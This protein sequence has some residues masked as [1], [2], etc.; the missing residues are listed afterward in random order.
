[1][2]DILVFDNE[3]AITS[4]L[5]QTMRRMNPQFEK[6]AF[7]K[8][9]IVA[10]PLQYSIEGEKLTK[11]FVYAHIFQPSPFYLDQYV[12]LTGIQA[13]IKSNYLFITK[14]ETGSENTQIERSC[15]ILEDNEVFNE[16]D[17]SQSYHLLLIDKPVEGRYNQVNAS[18]TGIT[19]LHR[20]SIDEI[21]SYL[22]ND[23]QSSDAMQS[24]KR[25]VY[26]LTKGHKAPESVDRITDLK[27]RISLIIDAHYKLIAETNSHWSDCRSSQQRELILRCC[28]E[29]YVLEEL[30]STIIPLFRQ[31]DE[32]E[33]RLLNGYLAFVRGG[34]PLTAEELSIK[35]ILFTPQILRTAV[36]ALNRL[37]TA[38][39]VLSQLKV[40]W[41]AMRSIHNETEAYLTKKCVKME[42]ASDDLVPL[43]IMTLIQSS[44]TDLVST[45][46]YISEFDFTQLKE[47]ELGFC[48]SSFQVATV[49]LLAKAREHQLPLQQQPITPHAVLLSSSS[50]REQLLPPSQS[51]PQSGSFH[52]TRRSR[53][54][55]NPDRL[56]YRSN[57]GCP[58]NS[59]CTQNTPS[60][61]IGVSSTSVFS[62]LLHSYFHTESPVPPQ[63]DTPHGEAKYWWNVRG[64]GRWSKDWQ[65]GKFSLPWN[66]PLKKEEAKEE[67]VAP[68]QNSPRIAAP[69][70][71]KEEKEEVPAKKKKYFC[72][73][74]L[75]GDEEET[76]LLTIPSTPIIPPV[77]LRPEVSRAASVPSTPLKPGLVRDPPAAFSSRTLPTSTSQFRFSRESADLTDAREMR[78][79]FASADEGIGSFIQ[80]LKNSCEP[81]VSSRDW[82]L[83]HNDSIRSE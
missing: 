36:I 11:Q 15:R 28:I 10:I 45:V 18:H 31:K 1:M 61:P 55:F 83:S 67:T 62:D 44:L 75:E 32:K 12:S 35:P 56:V 71:V 52:A 53:L 50:A 37:S 66:Y 47:R 6:D 24:L 40:I 51:L 23:P 2:T 48:F 69:L 58:P 46:D 82:S 77:T 26:F 41:E 59:V 73:C 78:R 64:N 65:K 60:T 22:T 17:N 38:R 74:C 68:E 54:L 4:K 9:W 81:V 34:H 19:A 33:N 79:S 8:K 27:S 16:H 7:A 14:N 20:K 25:D 43:M 42:L 21:I 63:V 30:S 13:E 72:C 29:T 5:Y 3:K 49:F 80:G 57:E 70:P 76:P 39:S